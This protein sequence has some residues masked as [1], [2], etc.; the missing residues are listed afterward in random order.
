MEQNLKKKYMCVCVCV[1]IWIISLYTWNWH[2]V[3]KSTI[4]QFLKICWISY[5]AASSDK[6]WRLMEFSSAQV[7]A[8]QAFPSLAS[9]FD[10]W[11]WPLI[12]HLAK[13][14]KSPFLRAIQGSHLIPLP[15]FSHCTSDKSLEYLLQI[16]CN[17]IFIR[18]W[19]P[20]REDP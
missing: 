15:F 17:F 7:R 9:S 4:Y 2:Y 8:L 19:I 18:L 20:G 6:E 1:C 12:S 5:E 16:L 14:S 10:K 11:I 13:S 3:V